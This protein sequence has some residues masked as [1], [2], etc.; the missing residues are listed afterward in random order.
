[1]RGDSGR[2]ATPVIGVLLLVVVAVVV[3]SVA[4]AGALT[5]LDGFG[6]PTA[7]ADFSYERT[8]A[9]LLMTSEVI[10]TDVTVRL[11]GRD[12]AAFD[13]D[14][15]GQS[16]LLPTAPGDR[17]TVVSQDGDRSVLVQEKIDERSEIGDFIAYYTFEEGDDATVLEDQSGNGN[18]GTLEDDGSG[19]GPDWTGCGLDFDGNSEYVTVDDITTAETDNV[20]EFT[21]AIAYE[22][23]G[24]ENSVNQ[25]VE[26]RFSGNEWFIETSPASNGESYSNGDS[27]D[28]AVEYPGHVASSTA[29]D[30]DTRHVVV[31][32]YDGTDYELYVDGQSVDSGSH[33]EAVGMGT[34]RIGRDYEG[35]NQYLAG[36]ICEMR[37]Y[38]TAFDSGEVEIISE[39]MA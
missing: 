11:N 17:I 1:M 29:V 25:L 35:T 32:T 39:E 31:G 13:P 30:T 33:S 16:V 2:A 10:G 5:F 3:G 9:G 22:Q 4:A 37:L 7:T 19:D 15:A 14:S 18:D 23:T 36:D 34:M 6:T 12:V 20:E 26:H 8:A 28:Y 38:F 21:V 24:N 27:V